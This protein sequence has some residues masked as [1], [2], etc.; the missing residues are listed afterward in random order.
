M[1][2]VAA[3]PLLGYTAAHCSDLAAL[4]TDIEAASLLIIIWDISRMLINILS[5]I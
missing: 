4:L 3:A 2:M 1:T 5:K